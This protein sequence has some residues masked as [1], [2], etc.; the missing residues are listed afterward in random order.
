MGREDSIF[1]DAY[2]CLLSPAIVGRNDSVV[3]S[4]GGGVVVDLNAPSFLK[5]SWRGETNN[6]GEERK[7]WEA[8]YF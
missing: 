2:W 6:R 8:V 3:D 4:A 7:A 1:S 5:C